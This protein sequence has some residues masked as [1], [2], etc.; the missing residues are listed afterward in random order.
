MSERSRNTPM[1]LG[2]ARLRAASPA[3]AKATAAGTACG[4]ALLLVGAA[5]M[6][7]ALWRPMGAAP[8]GEGVQASAPP[9]VR[10]PA[11]T[12]GPSLS[13]V[14]LARL[15]SAHPF[16]PGR[17]P[18][19]RGQMG[20]A[21]ESAGTV[22]EAPVA[23]PTAEAGGTAEGS[24]GE[25]IVLSTLESV[26]DNVK[27]AFLNLHLHAMYQRPVSG[28][29]MAMMVYNDQGQ[30]AP[31]MVV[32]EGQ[33]F[34]DPSFPQAPWRI[35][36]VDI[37]R[38]RVIVARSGVSL[39]LELFEPTVPR[40]ALSGA[41]DGAGMED[42]GVIRILTQSEEE[43]VSELRENGISEEEIAELLADM[44]RIAEG[45]V[46]APRAA[47]A[48]PEVIDR[49]VG[50]AAARADGAEPPPEGGLGIQELLRM[51]GTGRNPIEMQEEMERR[52]REEQEQGG[53]GGG[54]D[55]GTGGGSGGGDEGAGG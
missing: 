29:W 14:E 43:M 7:W 39:A 31:T 42:D 17:R 2:R 27:M 40:P 10:A 15:K 23:A 11:Q 20:G 54:G 35:R 44:G 13:G 45:G 51:M 34:T 18:F 50:Q 47:V 16:S 41:G 19:A 30:D 21:T 12:E 33:E 6:G 32:G 24:A 3:A 25:I 52:K 26:P 37:S 4:V 5:A 8:D 55:G 9:A 53:D 28:E 36:R 46:D 49:V 1:R 38:G 48:T 22:G